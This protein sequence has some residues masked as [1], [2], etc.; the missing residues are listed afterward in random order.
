MRPQFNAQG[1]VG[2]PPFNKTFTKVWHIRPPIGG[3]A[4]QE[5][6]TGEVFIGPKNA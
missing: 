4:C 3:A 6:G 5:I 1:S 2:V